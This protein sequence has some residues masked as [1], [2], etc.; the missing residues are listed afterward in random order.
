VKWTL[1]RQFGL[2]MWIEAT[3][4][5]ASID[6]ESST[7]HEGGEER[8]DGDGD[9]TIISLMRYRKIFVHIEDDRFV[10]HASDT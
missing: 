2:E 3:S 6:R 8:V 7:F 9:H 4:V 1:G 5:D 10:G